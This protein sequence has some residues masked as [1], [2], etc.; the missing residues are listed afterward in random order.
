MRAGGERRKEREP[1][2]TTWRLSNPRDV[3]QKWKGG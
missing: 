3:L 2:V 1:E